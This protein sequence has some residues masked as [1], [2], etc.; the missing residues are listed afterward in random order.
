[1]VAGYADGVWFCELAPVSDRGA[2]PE[3]V[4][5][6]LG[7]RELPGES[8]TSSMVAFL[9][10]KRVLLVLDNCEHVIDPAGTLAEA[11]THACPQ[12]QVL[13]T[14]REALGIDGELLQPVG[15]LGVPDDR[16]L[17]GDLAVIPSVRLFTDR[18]QAVRPDFVLDEASGPVVAD[19]CR[20]LD[21]VP[22]AIELA[23][24]R[25]A[26]LTVTRSR[27]DSTNAF[28]C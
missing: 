10:Q 8:L 9:R 13:A 26:S 23:A 3:A 5:A 17:S 7:V 21:G 15:S 24:A 20:Q 27:S 11:I 1:M 16:A 12:V 2:V 4:A 14:S 19:I 25:V 28:G 18:A 22:L 6:C